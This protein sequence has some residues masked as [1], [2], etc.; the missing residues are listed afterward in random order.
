MEIKPRILGIDYGDRRTGIAVS[1]PSGMIASGLGTLKAEGDRRLI[2]QIAGIIEEYSP[3]L[4]VL[5]HPV[6]MNGSLGPRAE[7]AERF[8][9]KLKEA[10]GL[11]VELFD[12]RMSTMN[13]HA[14]MNLT[15]TRGKAR[16]DAV[17]TLSAEIILQNYMDLNRR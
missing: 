15:D 11:P 7:K 4:I 14:I 1:D 5:G 13:A 6:N 8:A 3:V 16:K 9:E 10:F 2:E 12:E 17:D